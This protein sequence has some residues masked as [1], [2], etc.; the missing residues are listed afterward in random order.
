MEG[1][2]GV[3]GA[4]SGDFIL[5]MKLSEPIPRLMPEPGDGDVWV[6]YYE[7]QE[8]SCWRCMEPGHMTRECRSSFNREFVSEQREN[9]LKYL[10]TEVGDIDG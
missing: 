5:R 7:G 3:Q 1:A 8:D 4:A 2:G 10:K 9:Q 6:C